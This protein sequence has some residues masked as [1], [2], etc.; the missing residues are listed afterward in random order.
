MAN[1]IIIS[2]LSMIQL[3]AEK[4]KGTTFVSC[5]IETDPRM[6][7]TGNPY[8]HRGIVKRNTLTGVIGFD[9]Q[10]GLDR[11]ANKENKEQ[12]QA[13]SRAWGTLT[14]DR[15][16]V[17]HNGNFYLQLQVEN[18]SEPR[19]FDRD[20]IEIPKA[21][22]APWLPKRTSESSS[23]ADL[24][25]KIIVRDIKMSNI[26]AMRFMGSKYELNEAT[27]LEETAEA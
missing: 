22:L 2:V 18:S 4:V 10:N 19:F 16:F 24:D 7:K 20:G 25:S 27:A 5:D 1:L 11:R 21:E 15:L 6:R 13:K 9:Y 14:P 23:Q 26:K 8:L 17:T 12:R 3:I